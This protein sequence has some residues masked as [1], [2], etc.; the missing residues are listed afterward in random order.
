MANY[1][2]QDDTVTDDTQV[3][4]EIVTAFKQS[5]PG[6]TDEMIGKAWQTAVQNDP[7]LKTQDPTIFAQNIIRSFQTANQKGAAPGG[8]T[9]P[10][11][12]NTPT[13]APQTAPMNVPAA[14][15]D[16][17][18][19]AGYTQADLMKQYNPEQVKKAFDTTGL[20]NAYAEQQGLYQKNLPTRIQSAGLA[21]SG[22]A[23]MSGANEKQWEGIDAQNMLQ[24]VGKQATLLGI[25]KDQ[26]VALE[27]AATAGLAGGKSAVE[28]GNEIQKGFGLF[29]DNVVKALGVEQQQRFNDPN[30]TETQSAKATLLSYI[31]TLGPD[32]KAAL[33]PI[34]T[35]DG[36]TAQQLMPLMAQYVP[37]AF[38]AFTD[39]A[40]I[41]KAVAETAEIATKAAGAKQS[42]NLISTNQ[43]VPPTP[44]YSPTG[45][46]AP[47]TGTAPQASAP[48]APQQPPAFQF[49][50]GSDLA[51]IRQKLA[52]QG[53]E[54]LAAFDKQFPNIGQG[55]TPAVP[56]GAPPRATSGATP[57]DIAQTQAYMQ[58][59]GPAP[60]AW[61]GKPTVP[62][63]PPIME[64]LN[65]GRV[66]P[67]ESDPSKIAEADTGRLSDVQLLQKKALESTDPQ[68][69]IRL[70]QNIAQLTGKPYK[71][72]IPLNLSNVGTSEG[73][74]LTQSGLHQQ[75]Q[76]HTSNDIAATNQQ[77]GQFANGG[78]QAAT[79]VLLNADQAGPKFDNM[80]TAG[81][82]KAEA[83]RNGINK[84]NQDA[85][86]L[87]LVAGGDNSSGALLSGAGA[88]AAAAAPGG[89]AK[90][91]GVALSALGGM[92]GNGQA[93][94]TRSDPKTVAAMSIAVQEVAAKK[95]ALLAQ[96]QAYA[97]AHNGD[98]MGFVNTPTYQH[99]VQSKPLVNP[100]TGEVK[101]PVTNDQRVALKKAGFG[102]AQIFLG[103]K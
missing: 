27:R 53:P 62:V 55:V 30:S 64:A 76:T 80:A 89:L 78:K 18:Q 72:Q 22:T 81:N 20:Q 11:V 74:H 15:T 88:A 57:Q 47:V 44:S 32:A 28:I 25:S 51:S 58:G 90:A 9:P 49:S 8:S 75:N 43:G 4:A 68:E 73:A 41:G 96:Q 100:T 48:G 42:Q 65:A 70:N 36:V 99:I 56:A 61:S 10:T 14:P 19:G 66:S 13:I 86:N 93:I 34:V 2:T 33:T 91:G 92:L 7:S 63:G 101:V 94:T 17:F 67:E 24:T 77:L 45:G 97:D 60:A 31:G 46:V 16:P 95:A 5:N 69:I 85:T 37:A 52:S 38:K 102:D 87:G 35:K 71:A 1:T 40:G 29:G 21:A 83:L 82:P 54:V 79:Q 12:P 26:Q 98:G 6:F 39:A 84:L 3:P 103:N 59:K 23:N 50:P